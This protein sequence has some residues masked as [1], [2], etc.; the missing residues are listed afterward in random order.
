VIFPGST[1]VYHQARPYLQIKDRFLRN[2]RGSHIAEFG[3]ALVLIAVA[4]IIPLVDLAIVP[5]RWMMAQE[6]VNNVTRQLA[7]C[8]SFSQSIERLKSKPSLEDRLNRLG[9]V[10]VRAVQLGIRAAKIFEA[11]QFLFVDEPGKLPEEWLPKQGRTPCTYTLLLEVKVDL[12]PAVLFPGVGNA[13]PGLTGPFP[14]VLSS[15]HAWENLSLDPESRQ[16][17]INE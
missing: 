3:A 10:R 1:R 13:V 17:F 16:F 7:F 6:L 8:E 12:C 2:D 11:G 5:V 9:G 4:L 15:C 14:M